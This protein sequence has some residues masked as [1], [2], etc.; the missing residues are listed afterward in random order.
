MKK[1]K[2]EERKNGR[3]KER[4]RERTEARIAGRKKVR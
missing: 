3:E 2:G 1:Y 4:K